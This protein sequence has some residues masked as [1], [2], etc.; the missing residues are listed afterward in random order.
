M[1]NFTPPIAPTPGSG[2]EITPRVIRGRFGD[3]YSQRLGDGINQIA[4]SFSISWELL[5]PDEAKLIED[6][7]ASHGAEPFLWP[8]PFQE[9]P[10]VW[11]VANY[12]RTY[13]DPVGNISL[14]ATFQE[15]FDPF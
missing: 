10:K 5:K 8:L 11:T 14:A 2:G 15:E 7:L 4:E 13:T 9:T 6:F 1:D 3:G 12:R